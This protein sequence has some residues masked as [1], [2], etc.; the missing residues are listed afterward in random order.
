MSSRTPAPLLAAL[1][2][3]DGRRSAWTGD[4]SD[5]LVPQHRQGGMGGRRS[6]HRL[7]NVVWL[8]SSINGAIESDPEMQAEAVRRGIK[9][10]GHDDPELVEV[11]H[12]VHGLVLL[13]DNGQVV[14]VYPPAGVWP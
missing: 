7:S 3:R 6:K 4:E 1:E 10:G 9:I 14:P 12:A 2:A 8:E 11:R 5:T 13:R